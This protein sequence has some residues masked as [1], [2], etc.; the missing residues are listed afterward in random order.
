MFRLPNIEPSSGYVSFQASA[1]L[2]MRSAFFWD[3][4]QRTVVIRYRRF[5]ATDWSQPEGSRN[6]RIEEGFDPVFL[7]P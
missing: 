6:P 2:W 4:T 3:I 7:D 1:A 5:G